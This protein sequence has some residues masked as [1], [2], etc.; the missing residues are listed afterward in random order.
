[1][2]HAHFQYINFTLPI[3]NG[4]SGCQGELL[5]WPQAG[6]KCCLPLQVTNPIQPFAPTLWKI[7]QY[8]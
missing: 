3:L 4:L 5:M 6:E 1:M 7:D 2:G 8:P